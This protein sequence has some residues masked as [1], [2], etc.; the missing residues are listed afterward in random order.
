MGNEF[1][2]DDALCLRDEIMQLT[3]IRQSNGFQRLANKFSRELQVV[4]DDRDVLSVDY[5]AGHRVCRSV[6]STC[7]KGR[8]EIETADRARRTHMVLPLVCSSS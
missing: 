3:S 1:Y 2:I 6:D 7:R 8:D 5:L 4:L